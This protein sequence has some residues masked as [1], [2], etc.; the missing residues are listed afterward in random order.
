M[1]LDLDGF[2]GEI[3]HAKSRDQQIET[4][5]VNAIKLDEKDGISTALG[6]TNN[7]INKADYLYI[8][9][10]HMI[11]I[12]ASDLRNQ[13]EEFYKLKKDTILKKE[14]ELKPGEKLSKKIK[15]EIEKGCFY[16]I[17]AELS[18]KWSGSI[19]T[20]ERLCR[21]NNIDINPNYSYIVVCKDETDVRI[22]D[23]I[24][25]KMQGSIKNIKVIT[26]NMVAEHL[27]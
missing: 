3:C 18:Q 24:S 9:D 27:S 20:I 23:L 26:T 14:M 8:K 6:F 4:S 17:R 25:H 12:E 13:S 2:Y 5:G 10:N 11:I 22:M 15:N 16:P 21:I 19:A 7:M 1:A